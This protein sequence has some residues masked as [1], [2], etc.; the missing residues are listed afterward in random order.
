MCRSLDQQVLLSAEFAASAGD[1]RA[2]LV[3]VGRYALRGLGR[4][5]ELFT[6]DPEIA[7]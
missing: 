6:L 2:R 4:P 1:A 3:S 7:A 5:V